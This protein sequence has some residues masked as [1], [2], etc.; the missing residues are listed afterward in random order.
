METLQN[1]R[2]LRVFAIVLLNVFSWLLVGIFGLGAH[3][4]FGLVD[5]AILRSQIF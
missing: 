2:R 4:S 3:G 1:M 5:V